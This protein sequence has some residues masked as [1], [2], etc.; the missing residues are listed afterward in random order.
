MSCLASPCERAGQQHPGVSVLSLDEPTECFLIVVCLESRTRCVIQSLCLGKRGI[1]LRGAPCSIQ[2]VLKASAGPDPAS[3]PASHDLKK[4]ILLKLMSRHQYETFKI[5]R[6]LKDNGVE[7]VK[8]RNSYTLDRLSSDFSGWT[9]YVTH[10]GLHALPTADSCPTAICQYVPAW[11]GLHARNV[12]WLKMH[13]GGA[14][15]PKGIIGLGEDKAVGQEKV[16]R[17]AHSRFC[18]PRKA[19]W[20]NSGRCV[21]RVHMYYTYVM[22]GR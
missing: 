16:S 17:V 2:C 5:C 13:G 12:V 8:L 14:L 1:G 10:W 20:A 9:I 4:V 15:A 7:R 21:P 18:H 19:Q 3:A 11:W 22:M 6:A